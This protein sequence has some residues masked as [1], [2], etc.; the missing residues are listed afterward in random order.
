MQNIK[1]GVLLSASLYLCKNQK[2]IFERASLRFFH[3]IESHRR[4]R[5]WFFRNCIPESM[6]TLFFHILGIYLVI[7]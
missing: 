4:E 3:L 5:D 7:K 6:I 1:L 2:L